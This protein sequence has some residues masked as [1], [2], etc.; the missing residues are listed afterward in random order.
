MECRA[1]R[2]S[3]ICG[4]ASGCRCDTQGV[5]AAELDILRP[6]GEGEGGKS[7]LLGL[8]VP[9]LDTVRLEG[10]VGTTTDQTLTGRGGPDS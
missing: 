4:G 7:T 5:C 2:Q 3:P 10:D 9:S 1:A 6:V 8:Q